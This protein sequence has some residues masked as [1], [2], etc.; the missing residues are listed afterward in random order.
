MRTTILTLLLILGT[1]CL[2]TIFVVA[3]ECKQVWVDPNAV[4]FAFDTNGVPPIAGFLILDVGIEDVR[5][6]KS[7]DPDGDPYIVSAN[8]LPEG[9]TFANDYWTWT[10]TPV[11]VGVHIIVFDV[12]D[13]PPEPHD[14]C[15]VTGA[16]V[17]QV[18]RVGNGVPCFLPF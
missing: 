2:G 4:P 6:V 15:G 11:Q 14:P 3:Q 12:I 8:S 7:C 13:Q 9:M 1:A 16:Y 17:V 5:E 18:R 10:P